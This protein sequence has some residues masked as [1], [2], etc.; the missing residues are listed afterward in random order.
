MEI[1][2][3]I[4]KSAISKTGHSEDEIIDLYFE[5][6]KK[7]PLNGSVKFSGDEYRMASDLFEWYLI[8]RI[9]EPLLNRDNIFIGLNTSFFRVK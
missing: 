4:I 5:F 8:G 7:I 2:R 6:Y 1:T 3:E 9:Q